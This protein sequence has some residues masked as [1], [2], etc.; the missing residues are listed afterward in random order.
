MRARTLTDPEEIT[1]RARDV[2]IGGVLSIATAV[3]TFPAD[4]SDLAELLRRADGALYG[5]K[6]DGDGTIRF[7]AGEPAH[8]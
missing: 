2:V 7:A 4:G 6:R 5:A 3:A 1:L 8:R